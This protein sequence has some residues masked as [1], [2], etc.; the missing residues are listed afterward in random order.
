MDDMLLRK[1]TLFF[2]GLMALNTFVRKEGEVKNNK[3]KLNLPSFANNFSVVSSID[4]RIRFKAPIL[5]N[6][7]QI[8]NYLISQLKS[9]DVIKKAEIN[10]YLGTIL[11][12]YD[13]SKI[14]G[15]T[16]EGVIMKLLKLDEQLEN[17]V[18]SIRQ[19]A[20]EG[21]NAI[22]NGIYD[23]SRGI[24]DIKTIVLLYFIGGA[25]Y[26]F[27]IRRNR[28]RLDYFT[29]LWWGSSLLS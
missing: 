9:I 4:G 23:Y 17:R 14:D 10:I 29:L 7:E 26:D 16:I 3:N 19:K 11:V 21:I 1:R 12:S 24:L 13:S 2:I 25:I 27:K 18:S 28:V 20:I 8:S 15:E 5:K 6:N 22:N